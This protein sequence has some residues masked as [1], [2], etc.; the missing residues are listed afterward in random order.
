MGRRVCHEPTHD[1][2][3]VWAR[4]NQIYTIINMCRLILYCWTTI[5]AC[6]APEVRSACSIEII[7]LGLTP[8]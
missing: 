1:S 2:L 7:P 8:V 6:N 5:S 3:S 4:S